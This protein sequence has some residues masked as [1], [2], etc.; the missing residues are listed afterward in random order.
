MKHKTLLILLSLCILLPVCTATAAIPPQPL[1]DPAEVLDGTYAQL[2]ATDYP[3][4]EDDRYDAYLYRQPE[5][6]DHFLAQYVEL[7]AFGHYRMEET[8]LDGIKAYAFISYHTAYL[9]PDMEQG[10]M[11]L[12]VDEDIEFNRAGQ[13]TCP[14]CDGSGI[15]N[16]C[17]GSGIL[18][19]SDR[20]IDCVVECRWCDGLGVIYP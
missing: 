3:L 9:I 18:S 4:T 2:I 14:L 8:T 19:L 6:F 17:H 15:C 20:S 12:L 5:D 11:L 16:Q 1:P 13:R 7:A 10:K